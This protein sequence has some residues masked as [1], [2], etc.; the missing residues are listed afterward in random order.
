MRRKTFD[1]LLTFGGVVLTVVLVVAGSLLLWG[2]NFAQ[3]NVHSQL[4]QQQITFPTAAQLAKPDGHEITASMQKTLGQYAGQQLTT[5]NQAKAYADNF[6]AV[7]LY[8]MPMHGV[9]SQISGAAM[10]QPTNTQLAALKTT[11][12][13]GTT[14]RGLLLEAYAFSEFG[15][16]ALVASIC[17]FILAAIMALLTGLGFWHL[18]RVDPTEEFLARALHLPK[19]EPATV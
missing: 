14:L 6:I 10:A 15:T 13:Q 18:R 1:T 5:G 9:Y 7:H 17:S 12:F 11:S 4:A 16:I 19:Q 2:H 3:S 8:G